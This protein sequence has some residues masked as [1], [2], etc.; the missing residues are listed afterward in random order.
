MGRFAA[1]RAC[2]PS[3][4]A[5][6]V[7]AC[8][9]PC[10]RTLQ[11]AQTRCGMGEQDA[12]ASAGRADAMRGCRMRVDHAGRGAP[13][14]TACP[15]RVN[16]RAA[17]P[18]RPVRVDW[19]RRAWRRGSV[20]LVHQRTQHSESV[21]AAVRAGRA[22]GLRGRWRESLARSKPERRSRSKPERRS[23]SKPGFHGSKQ[24][25]PGLISAVRAGPGSV[26]ASRDDASSG[27]DGCGPGLGQW[28]ARRAWGARVDG[29]RPVH[30]PVPVFR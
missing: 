20:G 19:G 16:A 14:H 23:R 22:C 9:P 11:E 17:R 1:M 6:P 2:P 25:A 28:A 7:R 29:R 12:C 21:R 15:V 18:C 5:C 30:V 8:P 27:P 24:A 13:S 3:M 4:R 10:E 26:R